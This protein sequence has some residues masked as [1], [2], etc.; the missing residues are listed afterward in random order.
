MSHRDFPGY[1]GWTSRGV[2]AIHADWPAY[3]IEH[4][5]EYAIERVGQ[6]PK[7]TSL[8]GIDD[9]DQCILFRVGARDPKKNDYDESL[10][11]IA[12]W[13]EDIL[14]LFAEGWVDG[15]NRITPHEWARRR[16]EELRG[17]VLRLTDGR[18]EP[19]LLPDPEDYDNT[20]ATIALVSSAGMVLTDSG[21]RALQDLM[22]A[23]RAELAPSIAARV[24]PLLAIGAFDTAVREACVMLEVHLKKATGTS[25]FGAKLVEC[26]IE[27]L[28]KDNKIIGAHL[29]WLRTEIRTCISF[30]RNDFMH[31]VRI[32]TQPQC[33]AL[34]CRVSSLYSHLVGIADD[35]SPG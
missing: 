25:L 30:V 2:I 10:L 29:K 26:Y 32:L 3:A 1:L 33:V 11:H 19:V 6:F 14:E 7:G 27:A 21:E 5:K 31:N 4:G 20:E 8:F 9:I 18:S 34:L 15:V 35:E 22:G 23:R 28:R 13:H 12:L 17:L 24:E 16:C